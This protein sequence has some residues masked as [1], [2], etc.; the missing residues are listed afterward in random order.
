MSHE[1]RVFI[2]LRAKEPVTGRQMNRLGRLAIGAEELAPSD[3]TL[4]REHIRR[5]RYHFRIA[6]GRDRPVLINR[7]DDRIGA[8]RAHGR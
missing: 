2:V 5:I 1:R 6:S 7:S 3:C 4:K 8:E